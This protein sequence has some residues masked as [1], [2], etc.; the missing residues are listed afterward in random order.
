MTLFDSFLFGL[1]EG[2]TEFLPISSTGHLILVGKLLG[3]SSTE[4]LKSFEIAIQLGAIAS[5]V[6]LYWRMFLRFELL[7][8][9]F[10]AFLPTGIVGLFLYRAIKTYFLGSE[11]IVLW[12][13]LLGGIALIVFE[14]LH[15]EPPEESVVSMPS[16]R[17]SF[18]IGLAQAVAVIP[19]VSRSGA[20]I[21]GGLL[22]GLPRKTIIEFSFLLAVPTMLAATGFDLLKSASS[23]PTANFEILAVGFLTSFVVALLSIRFLLAF[24]QKYTFISFGVYRILAALLFWLVIL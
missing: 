2:I 17:Q 23:F 5:V 6:V 11:Q 19:G 22:L 15:K 13:L 7:K 9:L 16:Y 8:K 10:V 21:L 24:I 18:L 12:A 14:L 3:L 1:V 20:T 4:F